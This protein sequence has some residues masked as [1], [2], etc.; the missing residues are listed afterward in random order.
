[1][2]VVGEHFLLGTSDFD[3]VIEKNALFVDKTLFIKEFMESPAEVA[4]ILRPRRFG[5]ST[6]LSMLKSFFSHG[7]DPESFKDYAISKETEV[8]AKHCGKY[9]SCLFGLERLQR[10]DLGGSIWRSMVVYSS[11]G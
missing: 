7:A 9:P 11:D 5:K 1:M 2:A 3:K 8:V 4:L 6:N 10:E